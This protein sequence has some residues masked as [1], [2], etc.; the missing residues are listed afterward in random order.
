[1]KFIK[2][3][4][5][6]IL[7]LNS[8]TA[9]SA[10]VFGTLTDET[11]TPL[12]FASVFVKNSTT[13]VS[14][15]FEGKYFLE[16]KA[17]TYTL[18][19]SFLGYEKFEKVVILNQNQHLKLDVKLT[20]AVS[21]IDEVEIIADKV[22]RAKSIMKNVRAKRKDYLNAVKN[23]QCEVYAKT[24]FEK[25]YHSKDT[26]KIKDYDTTKVTVTV[27]EKKQDLNTVLKKDKLNLI[28]YIAEVYYK[29]PAHYKK[30]IKAYHDFSEQKP[31]GQSIT[32][33]AGIEDEEIAPKQ[34]SAKNPYLFDTDNI[35]N[36]LN[37]SLYLD[38]I[39]N[40]TNSSVN[41]N[42]ATTY[43]ITEIP[44]GLHNWTVYCTDSAGNENES[45]EIRNITVDSKSP[46]FSNF[47][48]NDTYFNSSINVY[49]NV[50]DATLNITSV[51]ITIVNA[52]NS[53]QFIADPTGES[54]TLLSGNS[55]NCSVN[56]TGTGVGNYTFNITAKDNAS[57]EA[58]GIARDVWF[59]FDNTKPEAQITA[60]GNK[61]NIEKEIQ[62]NGTANDT[63]FKED[64]H[65]SFWLAVSDIPLN[66]DKQFSG[67]I[68]AKL[69]YPI[70]SWKGIIESAESILSQADFNVESFIWVHF[71]WALNDWG[72]LLLFPVCLLN[73]VSDFHGANSFSSLNGC[74]Q[75]SLEGL[76]HVRSR[77]RESRERY[78]VLLGRYL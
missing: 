29:Q 78:Y 25:E 74:L 75:R 69:N 54:C 31:P 26:I 5:F 12:P 20:R 56:W 49:V 16:L 55:Y 22:D 7:I 32:V 34:Y 66:L 44:Q 4:L 60:P 11:G 23:Y 33:Q 57:N 67:L 8:I 37:C 1:M 72:M 10:V 42:T 41:N 38:G 76:P 17:G 77:R 73:S 71:V 3:Y 6:L 19:Y 58:N 65:L 30:V 28:E 18:I 64:E 36:T 46:V 59:V 52:T 48:A 61:N 70:S 62:I 13:G 9:D 68:K 45:I 21:A 43:Q 47:G 40:K 15:N 63:N 53:Q 39:L 24:S 35:A 50:T 14:A 27:S 2:L 51:N